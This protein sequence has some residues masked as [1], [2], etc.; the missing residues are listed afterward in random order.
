MTPMVGLLHSWNQ[1]EPGKNNPQSTSYAGSLTI[2]TKNPCERPRL[3]R[4]LSSDFKATKPSQLLAR[5]HPQCARP[6][7]SHLTR[8]SRFQF[9]FNVAWFTTS[10]ATSPPKDPRKQNNRL[11]KNAKEERTCN[12]FFPFTL[13]KQIECLGRFPGGA[14]TPELPRSKTSLSYPPSIL[15]LPRSR[16]PCQAK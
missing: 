1:V 15:S 3:H 9:C 8:D 12:L 14:P 16:L 10:P 5:P 13:P 2:R 6:R 4:G 11:R 7:T